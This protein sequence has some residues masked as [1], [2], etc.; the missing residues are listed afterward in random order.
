MGKGIFWT[1]TMISVFGLAVACSSKKDTLA[2]S[3][4]AHHLNQD[5]QLLRQTENETGNAS[6]PQAQIS[7]ETTAAPVATENSDNTKNLNPTAQA[8]PISVVPEKCTENSIR[9]DIVQMMEIQRESHVIMNQAWTAVWKE[10]STTIVQPVGTVFKTTLSD[11]KQIYRADGAKVSESA[12]CNGTKPTLENLST[13]VATRY[14]MIATDCQHSDRKWERVTFEKV[15]KNSWKM[16]YATRSFPTSSQGSSLQFLGKPVVCSVELNDLM[17]VSSLNCT[18][19]GQ[20]R[21]SDDYAEFTKFVFSKA[22]QSYLLQIQG[23]KY[24]TIQDK[25]G[26]FDVLVPVD[27]PILYSEKVI[28]AEE[29][30][31]AAPVVPMAAPVATAG[32]P[33]SQVTGSVETTATPLDASGRPQLRKRISHNPEKALAQDLLKMLSPDER[34]QYDLMKPEEQLQVL[35]ELRLEKQHDTEMLDEEAAQMQQREQTATNGQPSDQLDQQGASEQTDE[36]VDQSGVVDPAA[37][38]V[39]AE[40]SSAPTSIR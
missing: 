3:A 1:I 11:F 13:K 27:G 40:A 16:T 21:N 15:A 22:D 36:S 8:K 4:R 19:L 39:P 35:E 32:N 14:V 28:A 5:N 33:F 38:A 25:S 31:V 6:A 2:K 20:N 34:Q 26:D 24:R 17:K 9:C 12:I 29:A 10:N 23:A 7:D 37:S 30:P 18:G